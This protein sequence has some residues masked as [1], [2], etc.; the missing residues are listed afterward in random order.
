MDLM[1][2]KICQSLPCGFVLCSTNNCLLLL[3]PFVF[4]FLFH[5]LLFFLLQS[6]SS[7]LLLPPLKYQKVRIIIFLLIIQVLIKF[8]FTLFTKFSFLLPI[9]VHPS[10]PLTAKTFHQLSSKLLPKNPTTHIIENNLH[11]SVPQL[12][13]KGKMLNFLSLL[14]LFPILFPIKL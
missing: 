14:I 12:C 2:V 10:S 8:Q 3:F 1:N 9:A 11:I 6:S 4:P 5:L 7:P 13:P